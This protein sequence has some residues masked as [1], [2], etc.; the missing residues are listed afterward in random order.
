[1]KQVKE[2]R[3]S[4]ILTLTRGGD[5]DCRADY[6]VGAEDVSESRSMRIQLNPSQEQVIRNFGDSILREIKQSEDV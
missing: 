2:D 5:I 6:V 3:L 4:I 1:M